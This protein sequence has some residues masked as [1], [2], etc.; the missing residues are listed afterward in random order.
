MPDSHLVLRRCVSSTIL[1]GTFVCLAA[2]GARTEMLETP[3][4]NL[5]APHST[6]GIPETNGVGG[7]F[8]A[9]TSAA[10]GGSPGSGGLTSTPSDTGGMTT[11]SGGA[12]GR[13]TTGGTAGWGTSGG[14]GGVLA[15][16]GTNS[17][18]ATGGRGGRPVTG[19]SGPAS[20][21]GGTGGGPATGGAGGGFI[22]SCEYP[23]CLWDLIRDCQVA[24]PCTEDDS[25]LSGS[26]TEYIELCC[27]NG[28]NELI[29][30]RTEG[31]RFRGT[32]AVTK[33]GNKCYDVNIGT[34]ADGTAVDYAWLDPSGQTVAKTTLLLT[35]SDTP[36]VNCANGESMVMPDQCAP[37]GS[38]QAE[39]T[40]GSCQVD[41][42]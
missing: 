8:V 9:S 17:R 41:G 29:T 30:I 38:Q 4:D 19:G 20:A 33:S 13:P 16:G 21:T 34:R 1:A 11:A 5:P 22:G 3:E 26:T 39:V 36:V 40:T 2:C 42:R 6:G 7:T 28:V 27:A 23:S 25:G 35:G 31:S 37:D 15:T 12:G 32:V 18:R 24:G 10:M 14:T